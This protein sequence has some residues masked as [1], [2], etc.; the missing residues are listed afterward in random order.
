MNYLKHKEHPFGTVY[1]GKQ[2]RPQKISTRR[3]YIR[4][5]W[6]DSFDPDYFVEIG[7]KLVTYRE[8]VF[9]TKM[10]KSRCPDS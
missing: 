2:L 3:Y 8:K 7:P 9:P 1:T 6:G 5:A 10:R 4:Y